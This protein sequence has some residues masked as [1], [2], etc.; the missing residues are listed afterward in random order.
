MEKAAVF[1]DGG[2]FG[3]ILKDCFGSSRI[4]YAK[5]CDNLCEKIGVKRL[6]SYYYDCMPVLRDNEKD[7][8]FHANKQRFM[9]KIRSLPRF[10]VSLGR[11]QVINGKHKQKMVD[12][13]MS[14]DIVKSCFERHVEHA[15]L[16]A[17]DSDFV[18]A[19]KKA[20]EEGA[21]IHL[22]YH[23]TSVHS[24]I[25]QIVDERH[26]ITEDMIKSCLIK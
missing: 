7:K 19:I 16:I 2:Y 10:E 21:I 13:N 25:K 14:L 9:E 5:F 17:G 1:I 4:D 3:R 12:V 24:E 18:P 15:I 20:K 8:Q 22:V 6:R 11:L 23:P 26:Q